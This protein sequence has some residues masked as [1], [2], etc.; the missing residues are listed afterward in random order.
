MEEGEGLVSRLA[1]DACVWGYIHN[2]K[3][4]PAAAA[5]VAGDHVTH[6]RYIWR[7]LVSCLARD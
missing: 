3:A 2:A 7:A 6:A 4:R 1:I 5:L